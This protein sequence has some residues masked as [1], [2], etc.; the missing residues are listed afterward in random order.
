M[1]RRLGS[2]GRAVSKKRATVDPGVTA[3]RLT[4]TPSPA[5]GTR[6]YRWHRS[7]AAGGDRPRY[8][9]VTAS[10][11]LLLV[12]QQGRLEPGS[13]RHW[14]AAGRGGTAGRSWPSPTDAMAA[15]WRYPEVYRLCLFAASW[16]HTK[17]PPPPLEQAKIPGGN[18]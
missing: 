16:G 13:R 3:S 10:R 15:G 4:K 6:K 14:R 1:C 7:Y 17:P 8:P 11:R 9:E 2:R 5:G 12:V 18:G